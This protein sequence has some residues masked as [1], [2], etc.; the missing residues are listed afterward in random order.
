MSCCSYNCLSASHQI[1]YCGNGCQSKHGWFKTAYIPYQLSEKGVIYINSH[2]T[3]L[4]LVLTQYC[5]HST[6]AAQLNFSSLKSNTCLLPQ[7]LVNYCLLAV[8]RD[9]S[10]KLIKTEPNNVQCCILSVLVSG[11]CIITACIISAFDSRHET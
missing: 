1:R 9:Q 2:K 10:L 4:D 7:S 3:V 8:C 11:T 6:M 5:M